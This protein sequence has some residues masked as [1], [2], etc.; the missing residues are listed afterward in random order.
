MI[1]YL[2]GMLVESTPTSLIIDVGGIGY[3]V[4][5]PLSSYEAFGSINDQ[6]KVLTY[7]HVREDNVQL[8]GFAT[9]EEREMFLF[10]ISVSGI[11]PRLGQSILSG[12][13]TDELREHIINSDVTAL[14]KIR[15]IGKKTAQRLV[16]DLR[17]KLGGADIKTELLSFSKT[18][19]SNNVIE[20]AMLA[21]ISLGYNKNVAQEI[22]EKTITKDVSPD[23][24]LNVEELLKR[25]LRNI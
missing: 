8:F 15:G 21:L 6:I 4:S 1:Q 9:C 2:K 7:L 23:E 5:I 25:A 24:H 17:E 12:T 18:Q 13:P 16:V 11:G 10:L 3:E 22:M 20:E 14:S 19:L